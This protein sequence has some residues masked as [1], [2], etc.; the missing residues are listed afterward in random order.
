MNT[1]TL[2]KLNRFF[3]DPEWHL[4]EGILREYI[5][6]LKLIDSIDLKQDSEAV[7]A[8]LKANLT[9]TNALER[10]LADVGMLRKRNTQTSNFK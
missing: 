9:A 10:F 3:L 8:Q 2:E 6:P 4:V 7:H 1:E 5:E